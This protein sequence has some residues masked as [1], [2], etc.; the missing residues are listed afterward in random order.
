[1]CITILIYSLNR[2]IYSI[3]NFKS[4]HFH[5]AFPILKM[6]GDATVQFVIYPEWAPDS[7]N[8]NPLDCQV[9][10][11]LKQCTKPTENLLLSCEKRE[12]VSSFHQLS[13]IYTTYMCF[14]QYRRTF[15]STTLFEGTSLISAT[16]DIFP[17]I[18]TESYKNFPNTALHLVP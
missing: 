17:W 14:I 2:K 6:L 16:P 15:L 13:M 3:L 1:M 7:S 9:W 5:K 4:W 18:I 12:H 10:K 8:L 11:E